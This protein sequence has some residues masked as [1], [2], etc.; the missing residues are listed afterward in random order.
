MKLR[1]FIIS[2]VLHSI[3][4]QLHSQHFST[5]CYGNRPAMLFGSIDYKN[6]ELYV[7][8]VTNTITADGPP[9]FRK[10]FFGKITT[11]GTLDSIFGIIDSNQYSYENFNNTLIKAVDGNYITTGSLTDSI[12]KVFLMKNDTNG[13]VL[14]WHEYT[15]SQV[16]IYHGQGVVEIPNQ[17]YLIIVNASIIGGSAQVIIIRT[18]MSGNVINEQTYGSSNDEFPWVI[19][20][21]FNGHYMVGVFTSKTNTNTPYWAKTWLI[22]IDSMGNMVTQW[23]DTNTK[24]MWPSSMQQTADSGWIIVRQ[25]IS[26]DVSDFQQYDASVVK[27]DKNFN[28]EWEHYLGDSSDVTGFYDIEIL[29]DG[30]YIAC[31]TTPIWGSDSAHRFGWLVK[32]DTDGTL[33]WD[34]KYVAYER[35]GTQSFLYDIDVLPNGDFLACG[36]LRFTF[37][38]GITPV[39]QGWILRTDSNGCVLDNCMVGIEETEKSVAEIKIYPN[40]THNIFYMEIENPQQQGGTLEL[41]DINGRKLTTL[42]NNFT[43]QMMVAISNYSNGIYFWSYTKENQPTQ[44]GKIV[45]L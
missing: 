24:T 43:H 26:Y 39:Q 6:D 42:K 44:S 7:T 11:G 2:V 37:N 35:F 14:L 32:F 21:M 29:P 33:L 9:Y 31:G 45:K 8:G 13:N 10:A 5:L 3:P 17:G 41:Y 23:F 30:K 40:P 34:R 18:D 38:V 16:D 4:T 25:H 22:E 36:E 27:Y 20:P 28:K 12:P 15:H 1:L 19:R